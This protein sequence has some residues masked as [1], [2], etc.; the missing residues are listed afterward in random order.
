[1][2]ETRRAA[3]AVPRGLAETRG[4]VLRSPVSNRTNSS[5]T[6]V[7][8]IP[9]R[10]SHAPSRAGADRSTVRT[11]LTNAT[12]LR[13]QDGADVARW[14]PAR[15]PLGEL[16]RGA[17]LRKRTGIEDIIPCHPGTARLAYAVL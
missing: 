2:N 1:M 8:R 5:N 12:P 17:E 16:E 3:C 15:S 6:A 4:E 13:S 11:D 9:A 14:A 10:A 7:S